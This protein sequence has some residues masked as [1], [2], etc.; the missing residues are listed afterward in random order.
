[1]ALGLQVGALCI[2]IR[3]IASGQ[4]NHPLDQIN[5]V[6]LFGH[7]VL[8]LQ[9]GIH[10][11]KVKFVAVGVVD[12]FYGS[13]VAVADAAQQLLGSAMQLAANRVSQVGRRAFLHY[14][15]IAALAGAVALAQRQRLACAVTEH[16]HFNMPGASDKF[17]QE[18]AIIGEVAG[19]KPLDAVERTVQLFQTV[20]QLHTDATTTGG[21]FQHH[22]VANTLGGC[23]RGTQVLQQIGTRQQRHAGLLGQLAGTVLEAKLHHLFRCGSN[24]GNA[25]RLA[26]A[27]EVGIFTEKAVTGM[28]GLSARL[29]R[30][31]QQLIDLQVGIGCGAVT[32]AKGFIGQPHVQA[33]SVAL[34]VDRD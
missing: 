31:R 7:A 19:A 32:Q 9:A 11:K 12:E 23:L 16:L 27:H 22:R 1:M 24:K 28:D 10:F 30:N 13:G 8:N 14:F 33:F 2:Q 20:A 34:G 26:A 5:T 15:L 4:A 29:G 3:R 21:A 25:G 18:H 6:N 17:F